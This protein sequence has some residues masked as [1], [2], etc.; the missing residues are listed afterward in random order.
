MCVWEGRC[1]Q[2][3]IVYEWVSGKGANKRAKIHSKRLKDS[4]VTV[5]VLDT[6]AHRRMLVLS[7]I[8]GVGL[9]CF[10]Y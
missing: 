4:I 10:E 2:V 7:K 6:A 8:V 3:V 5:S 1:R 9:T